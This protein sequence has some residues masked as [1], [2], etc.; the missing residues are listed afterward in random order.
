MSVLE[1]ASRHLDCFY[2]SPLVCLHRLLESNHSTFSNVTIVALR[3]PDVLKDESQ[4]VQTYLAMQ[5]QY[6]SLWD[7]SNLSLIQRARDTNVGGAKEGG[8]EKGG[9]GEG[10]KPSDILRVMDVKQVNVSPL[11]RFM[12]ERYTR[13]YIQAYKTGASLKKQPTI[14][15]TNGEP[16]LGEFGHSRLDGRSAADLEAEAVLAWLDARRGHTCKAVVV[17]RKD[18]QGS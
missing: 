2:D 8:V 13:M 3:W 15:F 10:G 17:E 4:L 1:K 16:E 6:T 14:I 9:G 5:K 18:R 11:V 12:F 7:L